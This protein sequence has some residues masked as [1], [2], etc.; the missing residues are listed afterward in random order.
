[1]ESIEEETASL[2]QDLRYFID[3][4]PTNSRTAAEIL[5][6]GSPKALQKLHFNYD[7]PT[8]I[9]GIGAIP[10]GVIPYPS[11]NGPFAH[12]TNQQLYL[13]KTDFKRNEDMNAGL[14]NLSNPSENPRVKVVRFNDTSSITKLLFDINR[15]TSVESMFR[16]YVGR[17]EEVKAA[18]LSPRSLVEDKE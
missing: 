11:S 16:P 17:S 10:T 2:N 18:E 8:G 5:S 12:M 14:L 3:Y 4:L 6:S 13:N 9:T 15:C 1:M 7:F